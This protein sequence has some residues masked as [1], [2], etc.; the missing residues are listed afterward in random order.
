MLPK[1]NPAHTPTELTDP[2]MCKCHN[3]AVGYNGLIGLHTNTD[4]IF[5]LTKIS[6]S[7][8][9]ALKVRR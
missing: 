4:V 3:K 1:P 5:T 8:L 2:S 7:K 6:N 9:P